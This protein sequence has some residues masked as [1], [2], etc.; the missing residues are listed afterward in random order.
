MTALAAQAA[1]RRAKP[2][3]PPGDWPGW[4]RRHGWMLLGSFTVDGFDVEHWPETPHGYTYAM[5]NAETG[6][7]IYIGHAGDS[8]CRRF[9]SWHRSWLNGAKV[10]NPIV[11]DGHRA[12]FV[13]KAMLYVRPA[14]LLRHLGQEV[15]DMQLTETAAIQRWNPTLVKRREGARHHLVNARRSK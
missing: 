1:I 14:R 2:P 12:A 4:A 9:R 10:R 5:V 11:R 6:V 3:T 7:V 15:T 13:T 8:R